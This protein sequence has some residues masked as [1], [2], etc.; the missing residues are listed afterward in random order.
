MIGSGSRGKSYLTYIT[1]RH[2][3]SLLFTRA[4]LSRPFLV[5]AAVVA[6]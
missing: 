2:I 1:R 4:L 5:N 6:N 3:A